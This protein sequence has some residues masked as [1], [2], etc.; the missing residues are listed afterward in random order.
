[1]ANTK[2]TMLDALVALLGGITGLT[3]ATRDLHTPIQQR[4]NE[5]YIGLISAA[6]ESILA[7]D[8]THVLWQLQVDLVMGVI[9]ED[10]EELI[11]E[12]REIIFDTSTPTTIGAKHI[13]LENT[14]EVAVIKEDDYSSTRMILIITYSSE[15][16]A[17]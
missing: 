11:D 10:I 9:G 3:L 15:K 6:D 16:G 1:M 4:E 7:E 5:P 8:A 13:R 14:G 2:E 12:V 17:F